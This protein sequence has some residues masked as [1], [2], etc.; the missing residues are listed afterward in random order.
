MKY[1]KYSFII[2]FL[3]I[4][5]LVSFAEIL[6]LE[7]LK[8]IN[9]QNT[10]LAEKSGFVRTAQIGEVMDVVIKGFLGLL[11]MIFI[12][13]VIVAGYNWMTAGGDESKVDKAKKLISRAIIGLIIIIAA[14]AITAFVFTALDGVVQ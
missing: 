2:L 11:G 1:L 3:L 5:P 4:V 12:V 13:L 14:Y 6:K 8:D 7:T 10:A 9:D